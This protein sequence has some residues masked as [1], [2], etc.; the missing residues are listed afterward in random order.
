MSPRSR[1]PV[2]PGAGPATRAV[3]HGSKGHRRWPLCKSWGLSP[4]PRCSLTQ[5]PHGSHRLRPPPP[6]CAAT[7]GPPPAHPG[8]HL[9]LLCPN[10]GL[11]GR[12]WGA[13]AGG[14]CCPQ[15]RE[16]L[17]LGTR[18]DHRSRVGG[19]LP[20]PAAPSAL[21]LAGVPGWAQCPGSLPKAEGR[22]P[23][24]VPSS[25]RRRLP[26]SPK[27]LSSL[28]PPLRPPPNTAHSPKMGLGP[29]AGGLQGMVRSSPVPAPS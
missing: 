22:E 4:R 21:L 7:R 3:D 5:Q 26:P 27:A 20:S 24:G 1:W 2:A 28:S 10:L 18:R 6:G 23:A 14:P 19:S 11:C 8:P 29:A 15:G 9:P 16:G 13:R 17:G 25:P 12:C